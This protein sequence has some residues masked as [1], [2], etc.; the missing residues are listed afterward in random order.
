MSRDWMRAVGSVA[1][2]LMSILG[3]I[4][5]A[6]AHHAVLRFNLEEMT[7]TANRIFVGHCATVEETQEMIGQG[8]M[9]VTRYVFEVERAV[10]GQLPRQITVQQLGHPSHRALGKGGEV[11]MH[12]EA[13]TTKTIIHGMSSYQVGDRVLLFLIPN[14]L[15]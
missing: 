6:D 12:G 7:A 13:V 14:Y 4:P 15:G 2:L 9:P 11:T 3:A 1:I 5:T 8:M 10:K